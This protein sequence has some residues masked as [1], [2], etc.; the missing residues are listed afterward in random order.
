M[1]CPRCRFPMHMGRY[2]P[3]QVKVF[4]CESCKPKIT[5]R[6]AERTGFNGS[7]VLNS[8]VPVTHQER[9]AM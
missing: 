9:W 6:E 2:Y 7:L 8:K 1:K 3:G 5:R 4:H